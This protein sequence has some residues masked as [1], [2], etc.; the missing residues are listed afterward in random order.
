MEQ[1]A[2]LLRLGH[3]WHVVSDAQLAANFNENE[4]IVAVQPFLPYLIISP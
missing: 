4:V 1:L 3:N 2:F